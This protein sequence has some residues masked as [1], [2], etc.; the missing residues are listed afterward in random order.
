MRERERERER[1]RR[2]ERDIM[3]GGGKGTLPDEIET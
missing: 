3:S 2:G 1:E